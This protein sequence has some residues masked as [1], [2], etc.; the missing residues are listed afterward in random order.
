MRSDYKTMINSTY[1]N[2]SCKDVSASFNIFL[3]LLFMTVV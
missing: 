3:R 1:K 2:C